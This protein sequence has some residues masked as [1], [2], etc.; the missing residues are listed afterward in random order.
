MAR[1]TTRGRVVFMWVTQILLTTL[2]FEETIRRSGESEEI[3][4]E[5]PD[6]IIIV[7]V[8]FLC[9]ISM[10]YLLQEEI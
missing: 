9:G 2:L 5:F 1:I 10:H 6:S 3:S 8:R 4:Y 7:L